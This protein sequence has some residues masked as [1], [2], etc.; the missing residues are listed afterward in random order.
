MVHVV[1]HR[2]PTAV[3]RGGDLQS[4]AV[5]TRGQFTSIFSSASFQVAL[6]RLADQLASE[7]MIDY[8]VPGNAPPNE[9]VTVGVKI[10]GAR[11]VGMGVR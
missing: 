6:D 3:Q 7:L 2:P 10:P 1:E 4:L 9:D 11:V 8:I 5:Q